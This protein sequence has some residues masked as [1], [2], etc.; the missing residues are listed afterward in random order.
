M[1]IIPAR[2]ASTRFPQKVLCDLGGMPMVVRTALNAKEVDD[3]VVACDD[4]RIESVCKA[5]KI[6]CVMTDTSHNSGTDRCAQASE[7]LGL[8]D[9]EIVLNIQADEPFL[10]HEVIQTLGNLMR[11]K[12]PFMGTL[13]KVISQAD[14]IDSNL[15]KVVLNAK[16]EA[17]YFSR[18]PIPFC[19]DKACKS[20]ESTPYLGH[21][22]VYGY[23]AKHLRAFCALPQSPLEDIE[24]LE[25]LRALYYG[26]SIALEIVQTQS[27]GIDTK[28][29]YQLALERLQ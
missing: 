2:L 28:E 12:A 23:Y 21:L 11:E 9:D 14:I 25:Q 5:Y 6:D 27:M 22:G 15:V 3:V 10:E 29:D 4:I 16:N 18:A 8:G 13:A 26:K 1:I 24:K 7:I 19:R 17:L 20:L